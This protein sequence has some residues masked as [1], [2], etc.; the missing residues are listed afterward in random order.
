MC[1]MHDA[2]VTSTPPRVNLHCNEC[3]SII[4]HRV[5]VTSVMKPQSMVENLV[6]KM[7]LK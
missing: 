6:V 1:L 4:S 2:G 7:E 5:L 3:S